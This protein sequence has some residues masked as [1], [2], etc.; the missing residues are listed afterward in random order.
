MITKI[1]LFLVDIILINIGFLLSFWIRY[2][3]PFPRKGFAPYEN[4]F[5]FLTLIYI[6]A[7]FFLRL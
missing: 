2:G 3:L 5:I 6:V 1:I 4:S 7:L